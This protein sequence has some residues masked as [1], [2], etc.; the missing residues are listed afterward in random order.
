LTSGLV[1]VSACD[2]K[3]ELQ[4]IAIAEACGYKNVHA[5]NAWKEGVYHTDGTIVGDFDGRTKI[6]VPD[7]VNDLNEIHSAVLT[8]SPDDQF[9]WQHKLMVLVNDK[10]PKCGPFANATAE[11]R[12]EAFLRT[13][14]LWTE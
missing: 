11:T 4:R 3:P 7:F 2:M 1:S 6:W 12:A 13:L 9:V 8:L 5:F 14:N 10:G